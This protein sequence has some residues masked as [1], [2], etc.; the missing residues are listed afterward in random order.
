[1]GQSK[2]LQLIFEEDKEVIDG[3]KTAFWQMIL[4][5]EDFHWQINLNLSLAS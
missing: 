1:M 5:Q 4:E 3:V 2:Y